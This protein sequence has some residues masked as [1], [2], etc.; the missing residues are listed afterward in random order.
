MESSFPHYS[1]RSLNKSRPV[2]SSHRVSSSDQ[3]MKFNDDD[4]DDDDA[5]VTR[6]S[7]INPIKDQ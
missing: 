2:T 7:R 3:K 5:S 1:S 6:F 4:D